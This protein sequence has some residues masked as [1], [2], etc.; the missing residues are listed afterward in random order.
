MKNVLIFLSLFISVSVL[1]QNNISQD[2]I[3][4]FEQLDKKPFFEGDSE[5]AQAQLQLFLKNN[6][7]YPEESRKSKIDG[8]LYIQFVIETNGEVSNIKILKTREKSLDEYCN[9]EA[10]RVISIMPKWTPGQK[11]NQK[12][13]SSIIIPI[14]FRPSE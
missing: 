14:G 8:R 6:L 7:N 5:G 3:Y 13:R 12:V 9:K 1:C 10:I 2:S 4:K 11:N